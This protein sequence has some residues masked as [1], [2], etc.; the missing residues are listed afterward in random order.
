MSM[1]EP[2]PLTNVQLSSKIIEPVNET[3]MSDNEAFQAFLS[4]N[5]DGGADSDY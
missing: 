1:T 5:E 4:R 2:K 3:K